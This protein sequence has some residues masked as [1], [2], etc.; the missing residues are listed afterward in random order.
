MTLLSPNVWADYEDESDREVLYWV[1][2]MNPNY[3]MDKPGKSPMGMDLVPVY[4]DEKDEEEQ[5]DIAQENPKEN[6]ENKEVLYWVA[7]MNPNYRMDKPGK[8][9]MGMDLVPVYAD[10]KK[11]EIKDTT[12]LERAM[13]SIPAETIQTIGIRVEKVA[14]VKF[15]ALIRSYGEV[16][17]NIRLQSD[18]STRVSGWVKELKVRTEGDEVQKDEL[19]FKLDSPEL[20]SAQRDYISAIKGGIKWRIDSAK[21][22]LVSLGVQ[23]IAIKEIGK[24]NK[25]LEYVPFYATQDGIVS[26]INIR[27]GS[28]VKSGMTVIRIQN[29]SS[30]WVNVN[31]AEKDI[32]YIDKNTEASVSFP[33]LGIKSRQAKIDYIYPTIDSLTRTGKI[34]LILDNSNRKV[35]PGSFADIEFET[36]MEKRLSVPSNSILKSKTGDFVVVSM[37]EGRFQPRKVLT[38]VHYK[39]RTEILSGLKENDSIV[40]SGQFLIDSESSLLESFD[41]M[42]RM[43]TSLNELD[44]S[45]EQLAKLDQIINIVLYIHDQLE[46]NDFPKQKEIEQAVDFTQNLLFELNGTSIQ[47]ILE[48]LEKSLVKSRN[49]L[50]E[51]EWISTLDELVMILK[52]W[53]L[54]GNIKHYKEKNINVYMDTPLKKYWFLVGEATKSFYGSNEFEKVEYW[55]G[56]SDAR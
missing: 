41:K 27:Q 32:S 15:G 40:I 56:D 45:N 7:P 8:S 19:L 50:T 49:N 13:V 16:S 12:K 36:N 26:E 37:G 35:K 22:R 42:Q 1:A 44:I 14:M 5:I 17:E 25:E 3:R 21:A 47:F 28:H 39:G 6:D 23:D 24:K 43:K 48:D 10:N 4:A 20:I 33:N 11:E 38:G 31:V 51:K 18:I 54:E 9:P 55:N 53:V 34:R 30:V 46:S 29:Y 2:P 52:V